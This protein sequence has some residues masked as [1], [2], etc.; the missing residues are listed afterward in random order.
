MQFQRSAGILLHVTSL[1]GPFGI[2]DLGSEAFRFLDF[3]AA[4]GQSYWQILPLGPTADDG[5]PYAAQSSWAGSSLLISLDMLG[6]E[7][8]LTEAELDAAR[9]FSSGWVDFSRVNRVRQ[10][11]LPRAAE[12]FLARK[13]ASKENFESFCEKER[14]WLDDWSLF[15]AVKK[16]QA[17]QPWWMWPKPISLRSAAGMKEHR[18]KLKK[19][20]LVEKYIQFRFFEQWA[21]LK[22]KAE[23]CKVRIV[24][25]IPIYC[26]RD[27]ADVWAS[28]ALFQLAPN[29]SPRVVSGVP[30][31]YFSQNGQLWGTPVFDW[32]K[33]KLEG[34]SWW[35]RRLRAALRLADVVRI[36]HFRAFDAYWEIPVKA[37]SAKEGAWVQGPGND[38]FESVR[39]AFRRGPI[40]CGRF[41]NYHQIGA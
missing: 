7:A 30:P 36:D 12:R 41:R 4:S 13:G 40:Y 17:G 34:Y 23:E 37:S 19:E 35:I 8:D 39:K 2:G 6:Q 15:A 29:G 26:A 11:L 28:R 5:S 21:K 16:Q 3:L 18:R 27:S 22:Q 33:N 24:G 38:F 32:K 10:E 20:I 25:D 1:P 14:N 31:D 9:V